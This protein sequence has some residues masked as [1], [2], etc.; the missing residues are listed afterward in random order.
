MIHATFRRLIALFD[1]RAGAHY[2]DRAAARREWM[3]LD[4]L[5]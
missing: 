2:L 3:E 1:R 4:R 5:A